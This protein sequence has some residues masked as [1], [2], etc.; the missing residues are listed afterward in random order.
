MIQ[1]YGMIVSVEKE[2][3][4]DLKRVFPGLYNKP[5]VDNSG[6]TDIR[7][8]T[9][10]R[11][12]DSKWKN[13]S[14]ESSKQVEAPSANTDNVRAP[15]L[16]RSRMLLS[17]P[18]QNEQ[19]NESNN[20]ESQATFN[21][22][23]SVSI[24]PMTPTAKGHRGWKSKSMESNASI[25]DSNGPK[26]ATLELRVHLDDDW[27]PNI[28][29]SDLSA[30]LKAIKDKYKWRNGPNSFDD[31]AAKFEFNEANYKKDKNTKL[32]DDEA[33]L[34]YYRQRNHLRLEMFDSMDLEEMFDYLKS[35][36]N[37]FVKEKSKYGYKLRS[38][39]VNIQRFKEIEIQVALKRKKPTL[40][41]S[42]S[43]KDGTYS[44]Y[45]S[46]SREKL[47]MI[48]HKSGHD[49]QEPN[50]F[51]KDKNKNNKKQTDNNN[52]PEKKKIPQR[53][54]AQASN[55]SDSEDYN[56]YRRKQPKMRVSG[57]FDNND[58]DDSS[59]DYNK[60]RRKQPKMRSSGN[61]DRYGNDDDDDDSDKE[62]RKQQQLQ[63]Q[64][65]QMH[66]QQ[67]SSRT[68]P[69]IA[70]SNEKED[71]IDSIKTENQLGWIS[72]GWR[73]IGKLLVIAGTDENANNAA[74]A[75][76]GPNSG[77]TNG[78][79]NNNATSS[80]SG[81]SK[82]KGGVAVPLTASFTNNAN[83]LSPVMLESGVSVFQPLSVS[84][85]EQANKLGIDPNDMN[86]LEVS[87]DTDKIY[88]KL[89]EQIYLALLEIELVLNSGNNISD[90]KI[91]AKAIE[92]MLHDEIRKRGSNVKFN[93]F[94]FDNNFSLYIRT[95]CR[96]RIY[97]EMTTMHNPQAPPPQEN[98]D[99]NDSKK[100]NEKHSKDRNSKSSSKSSSSSSSR[101]GRKD[102][103]KLKIDMRDVNKNSKDRKRRDEKGS[104]GN[105]SNSNSNRS[106]ERLKSCNLI[107]TQTPFTEASY[108][109]VQQKLPL[110][111]LQQLE[112]L[113]R[114]YFDNS[115]NIVCGVLAMI[116]N[117]SLQFIDPI[118]RDYALVADKTQISPPDIENACI[119]IDYVKFRHSSFITPTSDEYKNVDLNMNVNDPNDPNGVNNNNNNNNIN[120][121]GS[122]G[123]TR[124][125]PL[126]QKFNTINKKLCIIKLGGLTV[127][128]DQHDRKL[129]SRVDIYNI[130]SKTWIALPDLSCPR[131]QAQACIFYGRIVITGGNIGSLV[132]DSENEKQKQKQKQ[133][134]RS[135]NMINDYNHLM[136]IPQRQISS[137]LVNYKPCDLVEE[138]SFSERKWKRL[139][140]LNQKRF[141]HAMCK[142]GENPVKLFVCAG[143]IGGNIWT[144]TSEIYSPYKREWIVVAEAN[145]KR[146]GAS[147]CE[148]VGRDCVV[149]VAGQDESDIDNTRRVEMYGIK[150]N[151]WLKLP[152]LN[153][154][155][156]LFPAVWCDA[157]DNCVYVA[158]QV[159]RSQIIDNNTKIEN[160]SAKR[161]RKHSEW[162]IYDEN[163]VHY[164][165]ERFNDDTTEWEVIEK[166]KQFKISGY[167]SQ[168]T[169]GHGLIQNMIENQM[170]S[171][172]NTNQMDA[173]CMLGCCMILK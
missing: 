50:D 59:D 54:Q 103:S 87:I 28:K 148:W 53:L 120:N 15:L 133:D 129:L 3:E 17:F 109:D 101:H 137:S 151:Q 30:K 117:I 10:I 75:P 73:D 41:K 130:A 108:V 173:R 92:K 48:D 36:E 70:K 164:Q 121:S 163:A 72:L 4:D 162:V 49:I 14:N 139:A 138:F 122:G 107:V 39:V 11:D 44:N 26:F 76:N 27:I 22:D 19:S 153:L 89:F 158:S 62:D 16:L 167:T 35:E 66:H 160:A 57:N 9:D 12:K 142:F 157:R 149:V 86:T 61:F 20:K 119:I 155:H 124:N 113:K 99:E 97:V 38:S 134:M 106:Q 112:A 64:K 45:N 33:N 102:I 116:N 71:E 100:N 171:N 132:L 127:E 25:S 29:D 58:S 145:Y 135:M 128:D 146:F 6:Q 52:I 165:I 67:Q 23:G 159:A 31:L 94:D 140:C 32:L 56:K 156:G 68:R 80:T 7:G 172:T 154:D 105:N 150:E 81:A 126:Q 21:E 77:N 125:V 40:T 85:L 143:D 170:N 1:Q 166:C 168:N 82:N 114:Y 13:K 115:D 78:S 83:L 46:Y 91:K 43:N 131:D 55:S 144:N 152:D 169:R 74:N 63:Q 34:E 84:A 8:V 69:P 95:R 51:N 79:S 118:R 123:R 96:D 110:Q 18:N 60:Y 37:M 5:I 111:K 147:A 88:D 24:H 141:G 93:I 104:N 47:K 65:Q 90:V 2:V 42:N 136:P 161:R 98:I